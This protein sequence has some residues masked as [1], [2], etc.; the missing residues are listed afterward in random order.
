[1]EAKRTQSQS[2]NERKREREREMKLM[3]GIIEMKQLN[4]F[5]PL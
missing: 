5:T 4:T 3:H 2:M 1:M